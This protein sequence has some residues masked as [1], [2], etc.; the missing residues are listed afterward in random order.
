MGVF[1]E[2]ACQGSW[3]RWEGFAGR[4][5][6]GRGVAHLYMQGTTYSSTSFK[7]HAVSM[8]RRAHEVIVMEGTVGSPSDQRV[9]VLGDLP[10]RV[11]RKE[12][13]FDIIHGIAI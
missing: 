11:R 9:L 13:R 6:E 7:W 3:G 2:G 8:L 10:E 12:F 1:R 4:W 5:I